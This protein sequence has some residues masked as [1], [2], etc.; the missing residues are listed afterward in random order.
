MPIFVPTLCIVHGGPHVFIVQVN[1]PHRGVQVRMA[2]EFLEREWVQLGIP[3]THQTPTCRF[4]LW[5]IT[6]E[7]SRSLRSD[8]RPPLRYRE[9]A[10]AIHRAGGRGAGGGGLLDGGDCEQGGGVRR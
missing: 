8:F 5:R 2:R 1:V 9:E 6:R 7:P 3:L 4:G 10:A